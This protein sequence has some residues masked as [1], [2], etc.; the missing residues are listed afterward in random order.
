MFRRLLIICALLLIATSTG[1]AHAQGILDGESCHVESDSIV[2]G[3]LFVF[4]GELLVEGVVEGSIIGGARMAEIHGTVGGSIYLMGGELNV[5][6]VIGKDV[7][8]VGVA[9]NI[10][11]EAEFLSDNGS[12]LSANLS[13]HIEGG[14]LIPGHVTAL[15]YQLV[16]DGD[17]G[18]EVNFWGSALNINGVIGQD[19]TATVG[20]SEEGGASSQIETLLIPFQINVELVDPGLIVGEDGAVRGQLEYTGPAL[21]RIEGRMENP[22]IF[23]STLQPPILV[24]GTTAEESARSIGRYL[25]VVVREFT[26]LA[27]VGVLCVLF[28]PRYIQS[29]IRT[30]QTNPVSTL[31][32]GLLSFIISFPIVLILALLSVAL[33]ALLGALRLDNVVMFAGIALGLANIGG[34]SVFY[35]AAIYIARVVV[36]LALGRLVI[37]LIFRGRDDGT[38]RY[39]VLSMVAGVLVLSLVGSI[40]VIGIVLNAL[41]LFFGLGAILSVLH[42]QYIRLFRTPTAPTPPP[43]T[44]S[45]TY[46]PD[47]LPRLP[48]LPD[49][50]THFPPPLIDDAPHNAG[51]DNLPEGFN[52]WRSDYDDDGDDGTPPPAR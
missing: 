2:R 17:I 50:A 10:L 46:A 1:V 52:W 49:E 21:G 14:S 43:V 6:G 33:I 28:V 29:P 9:L 15:G 19:V 23:N 4:C 41:A 24:G 40:P 18:G 48:Y 11:P 8:Y 39:L 47:F 5:G 16:V 26:S 45:A 51:T 30:L 37:R 38:W 31:G 34:A 22:P 36:A 42:A 27:F 32:I 13:H 35:F 44:A 3:N 7:H 12:I 25:R 20:H